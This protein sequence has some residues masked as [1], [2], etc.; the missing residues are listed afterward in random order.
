MDI[1]TAVYSKESYS[2]VTVHISNPG[3]T[4]IHSFQ[5]HLTGSSNVK[6]ITLQ[7]LKLVHWV[8]RFSVSESG[9]MEGQVGIRAR[10]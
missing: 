3:P 10:E 7:I 5:E 6:S 9:D 2:K 1:V 8:G 4:H